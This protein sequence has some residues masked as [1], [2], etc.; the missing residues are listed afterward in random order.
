M[1]AS[2]DPLL[3]ETDRA[4]VRQIVGNLLSNAIKYTTDGS[5]V[6]RARR[7]P[8]EHPV[9][10]GDWAVIEVRDTGRGIPAGKRAAIFEEFT[11]VSAG[12]TAGAG[13][14]LA[15]SQRLAQALGGRITV[16]SE[17]GHGSTFTLWLPLRGVGG[18]ISRAGRGAAAHE[19]HPDAAS[20]VYRGGRR[21]GTDVA[22]RG[23]PP[24]GTRTEGD[25][26][27]D[28]VTVGPQRVDVRT[29]PER[30]ERHCRHAPRTAE[31]AV[32]RVND[33]SIDSFPASDPPAWMGMRVGPPESW[34]EPR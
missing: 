11:R 12:E 8:P 23:V 32:D 7:P 2:I 22:P 10:T 5:V 1:D 34:G 20:N 6:L 33:D 26:M 24:L 14:G 3:V 31:Q 19:F 21:P 16:E 30:A 17:V 18:A 13:L 25:D 9:E 27:G 28:R 29:G 4:R 15:I